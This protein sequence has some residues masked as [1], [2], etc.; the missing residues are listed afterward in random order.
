[1]A[2]ASLKC[3]A[4]ALACISAACASLETQPPRPSAEAVE[5]R[6]ADLQ[7]QAIDEY[8][9][10]YARVLGLAWPLVAENA[11]LCG[12]R[13]RRSLGLVLADAKAA[14]RSVDGLR[15]Q[16][17][18]RV[19]FD[20]RLR[21]LAVGDGTPAAR[22]GLAP[23]DLVLGVG[24]PET[25]ASLKT[26]ARALSKALEDEATQ[27]VVLHVDSGD[28]A[29]A[30]EIAPDEV[31]A[32]DLSLSSAGRINASA[33]SSKI[34]IYSG[35]ARAADDEAL[36]FVI[37]HELAHAL[38]RHASKGTRASLLSGRAVLGLAAGIAGGG[39]DVLLAIVG[40]SP[41]V[42][43]SARGAALAALPFIRDFE[44]EADYAGVYLLARAGLSYSQGAEIFETFSQVQP[45]STW[46]LVTHPTTPERVEA[47]RAAIAEID[48]RIAAGEPL[49]PTGYAPPTE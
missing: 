35:L 38:L 29:R 5:A 19:G 26:V 12:E 22:A 10:A 21:I 34:T 20:D 8:A 31:C 32:F 24:E 39:A 18:E 28:G 44:R 30:V 2:P 17:A 4:L 46:A 49:Y 40:R 1:V 9:A 48:A 6:R 25:A 43:L 13:T 3:A 14:A 37:A 23:G 36:Q 11:D 15:P 41:E 42:P 33:T 47:A 27:A 45:T 7:K 16:D